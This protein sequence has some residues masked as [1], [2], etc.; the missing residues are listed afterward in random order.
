MSKNTSIVLG[1]HFDSFV[2]EQ[3][4][5]KR[6]ASA[7]E[8]VRAGLRLLEVEE[9][10]LAHLHRAL[11]DGEQSGIASRYSPSRVLRIAKKKSQSLSQDASD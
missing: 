6:Y 11:E 5:Q 8:L 3:L 2:R 9:S 4:R 1:D 7:S 10:K